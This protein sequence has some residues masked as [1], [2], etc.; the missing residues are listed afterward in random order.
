LREIINYIDCQLQGC[1]PEAHQKGICHLV[2]DDSSDRYPSTLFEEAEK[3]VPE[4]RHELT[5]YYRLLDGSPEPDE[6]LSFGRKKT[7]VNSQQVRVVMFIKM[8]CDSLT[9]VDDFINALPDTFEL[10]TSPAEYK[11]LT[12]NKEISL[13]RDSNAIWEDEYSDS[14]KDKY[15]K[16]FNIYA[17]EFSIEYIKC[18]VCVT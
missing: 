16:V 13:I 3:V 17:L 14:Y 7:I 12:I 9:I 1:F 10:D 18:P 6:D 5:Y 4:D 11:K 15:Q 8:D 2:E